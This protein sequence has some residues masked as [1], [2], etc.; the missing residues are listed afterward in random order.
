MAPL[1]LYCHPRG[2][3][4]LVFVDGCRG[5]SCREIGFFFQVC[6]DET[7]AQVDDL[8]LPD[9]ERLLSSDLQVLRYGSTTFLLFA[10][11]LAKSNSS[12]NA[13]LDTQP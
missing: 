1:R 2:L 4:G 10:S 11:G 13:N 7:N 5:Y 12:V 9:S 8:I 3:T 6:P